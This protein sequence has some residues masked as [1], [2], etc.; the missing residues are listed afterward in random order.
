[1]TSAVLGTQDPMYTTGMLP[2]PSFHSN[3]KTKKINTMNKQRTHCTRRKSMG[4]WKKGRRKCKQTDVQ[5]Q[6]TL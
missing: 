5:R 2:S 3:R 1:M 4:A 6:A